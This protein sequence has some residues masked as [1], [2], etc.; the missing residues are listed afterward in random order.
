MVGQARDPNATLAALHSLGRGGRLVLMGSMS[1][2]LPIPYT[3]LMFHNWEILGQFMYPADAYRRLLGLVRAGL[4][5][6]A[7]LRPLEYPLSDLPAA[8]DAAAT[9][10]NFECAVVKSHN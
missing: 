3:Q 5:D 7:V 1:A 9:A 10:T 8:M 6:I 4:L 2:E